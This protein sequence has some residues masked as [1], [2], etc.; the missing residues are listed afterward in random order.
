M[1]LR[2]KYQSAN[3]KVIAWPNQLFLCIFNIWKREHL[4]NMNTSNWLK[5]IGQMTIIEQYYLGNIYT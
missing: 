3:K 5:T 2:C 1:E 4:G